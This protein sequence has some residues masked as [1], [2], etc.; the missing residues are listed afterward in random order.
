MQITNV[1]LSVYNRALDLYGEEPQETLDA[2]RRALSSAEGRVDGYDAFADGTPVTPFARAVA[3]YLSS[4]GPWG[5]EGECADE[6]GWMLPGL[7]GAA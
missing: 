2:A 1:P 3:E 4:S 5:E 6:S 7:S